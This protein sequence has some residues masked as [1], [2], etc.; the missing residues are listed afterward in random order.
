M[1]SIETQNA[2]FE[3]ALA[4]AR[5]TEPNVGALIIRIGLCGLIYY[6][7]KKEP[8]QN[9][10]GNYGGPYVASLQPSFQ[11]AIALDAR[12]FLSVQPGRRAGKGIGF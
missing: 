2:H 10:L 3:G 12:R 1:P 9:S 7:H 5:K 11:E 6:I 8:P 4:K